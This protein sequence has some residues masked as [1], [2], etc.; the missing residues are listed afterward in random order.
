LVA[1]WPNGIFGFGHIM[2]ATAGAG[3]AYVASRIIE[4]V[5]MWLFILA[6]F[7]KM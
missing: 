2:P 6:G 3:I 7:V 5:E 1:I 4:R